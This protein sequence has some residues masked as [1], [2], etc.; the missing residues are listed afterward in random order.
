MNPPEANK[1]ANDPQGEQTSL[2]KTTDAA[3][4]SSIQDL[5]SEILGIIFQYACPALD[6][7]KYSSR[8]VY[9]LE[10]TGTLKQSRQH[11]SLAAV[12]STW[13]QVVYST[14]QLW[15]SVILTHGDVEFLELHIA[16]SGSLLLEL[17]IWDSLAGRDALPKVAPKLESLILAHLEPDGV[18]YISN[19]ELPSLKRLGIFCRTRARAPRCLGLAGAPVLQHLSFH[20]STISTDFELPWTSIT[21]LDLDWVLFSICITALR[22]CRNL[23]EFHYR[24]DSSGLGEALQAPLTL[25]CLKQL[26]CPFECGA[27]IHNLSCRLRTIMLESLVLVYQ[28]AVDEAWNKLFKN[29]PPTLRKLHLC[30]FSARRKGELY[31]ARFCEGVL[32]LEELVLEGCEKR[33]LDDIF[34]ALSLFE[35]STPSGGPRYMP[36]LRTLVVEPP[37]R[38]YDQVRRKIVEMIETRFVRRARPPTCSVSAV[39]H[40]SVYRAPFPAIMLVIDEECNSE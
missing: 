13:R 22:R 1:S 28:P 32:Y 6:F 23:V 12:S 18:E 35:S 17:E 9:D 40:E 3:P 34:A 21:S 19:L 5:F 16:K 29:L 10:A 20:N 24:G 14:P 11:F 8:S 15:T 39:T 4:T 33:F 27:I 26:Y 36:R 7:P 2:I 30:G 37:H 25:S 31:P 38:L